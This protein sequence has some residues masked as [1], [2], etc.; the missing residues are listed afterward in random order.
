VIAEVAG[1]D[2]LPL[3]LDRS[4]GFR[5]P[6]QDHGLRVTNRVAARFTV[7]SG[8]KVTTNLLEAAPKIDALWNHNDEQGRRRAGRHQADQW[9]S[10]RPTTSR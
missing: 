10:S 3:T 6:L 7:Q 4:K 8:Q 1:I 2:E 9:R 5:D